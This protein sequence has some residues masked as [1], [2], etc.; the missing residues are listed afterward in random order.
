M[1]SDS[2]RVSSLYRHGASITTVF[3]DKQRFPFRIKRKKISET[4]IK[5]KE[6]IQEPYNPSKGSKE[7]SII[8]EI[9]PNPKKT[10]PP[11]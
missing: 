11:F 6:I 7:D 3:P 5:G 9:K 1:R 8:D 2:P 4:L 10:P